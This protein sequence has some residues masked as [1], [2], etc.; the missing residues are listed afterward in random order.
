M[1]RSSCHSLEDCSGND[2]SDYW[3]DGD[4][5]LRHYKKDEE[6]RGVEGGWTKFICTRSHKRGMSQRKIASAQSSAFSFTPSL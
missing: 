3:Y 6:R 2:R 4:L 5:I 1:D